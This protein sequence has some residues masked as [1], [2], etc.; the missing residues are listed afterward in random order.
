[1]RI[2][3]VTPVAVGRPTSGFQTRIAQLQMVLRRAAGGR[4]A[5]WDLSRAAAV[6]DGGEGSAPLPSP[7]PVEPT[8][9][10]ATLAALRDLAALGLHLWPSFSIRAVGDQRLA[11]LAWLQRVGATHVVVIHPYATDLVTDL[12]RCGL[13]VFVDAQNVE[14]DLARQLV[15]LEPMGRA[16]LRALVKWASI[17]RWEKRLLPLADEVWVPSEIDAERQRRVCGGRARVRAVPNALDIGAYPPRTTAG[18]HDIL[19]PAY[20]GYRPNVVGAE[21][22]RDRVLPA[23]RRRVPDARLLLVGHD[24]LE[25]AGMLARPPEVIAT[26]T[27]PDTRPYFES[28][29]V[30]AVPLL[31]GGGTRYKILEA[32]ALGV[33]V[34]TTPLGCEGIDVRDGEHLLIRDIDGFAEAIASILVD[35]AHG[36]ALVERGR[37][38]VEAAYSWDYAEALV[39]AA[40][41][42]TA[43]GD[44]VGAASAH[45]RGA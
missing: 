2:A 13:R 7:A 4:L 3:L 40:L 16:R 1:M 22:L 25:L 28:A 20:Y 23:V 14:S 32:L 26:G 21:L 36:R 43:D 31:Q 35:P 34:V 10:P 19:S 33:P 42:S 11:I 44:R 24:P 5:I 45:P 9:V 27:V 37:R 17:T 18:S 30:L 39:R 41:R 29:G 12:H 38:L 6:P 15:Q 8:L